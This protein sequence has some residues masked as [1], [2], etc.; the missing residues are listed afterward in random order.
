MQKIDINK[1]LFEQLKKDYKKHKKNKYY[2]SQLQCGFD[3]MEAIIK[4]FGVLSISVVNTMDEELYKDIF[5]KNFK[6]APSLGDFKSLATTSFSKKSKKIISILAINDIYNLLDDL[7]NRKSELKLP[8]INQLLEGKEKIIKI[9]STIQLLNEYAISFRNKLK[10]HGA[11]FRDED[12]EQREIILGALDTLL[13][14]LEDNYNI[15]TKEI[16]FFLNIE[17][18]IIM[19][20]KDR[21]CKLLPII[22]YIECDKFSCS[23]VHKTKLFFYNDGKETKSHY[24]DYSYNH[25]HQITQN[26][27]IHKELKSLQEEILHTTSDIGRQ[28]LLLSTFVGRIEEL[29]STQE[30]ICNA[31]E[32]NVASFISIMGK[33]GIGKS[34]FLTQL[35]QRLEEDILL[36]NKFNSY[37]FYAQKDKMGGAAEEEKYLWKKLSNYFDKYG[38]SIKQDSNELFNLRDNLEKLFKAYEEKQENKPLLLMIDGLDEFAKPSVIVESIPLNISTKIHFI[39]SSRPYQNIKDSLTTI[40]TANEQLSILKAEQT[41]KEGYSLELNKLYIEEV[42]ELLSR[43]LSKDISRE[44]DEYKEIVDTIVIQSESLP[45][46]IYYITQELKEKNIKENQNIAEEII[47]WSKQLPPKLSNFYSQQFKAITPLARSILFLLLLSKSSVSKEDFYTLLKSIKPQE[48]MTV[49]EGIIDEVSFIEKHFNTIEVFLIIDSNKRYT[50]Y[51]HSVKEQ[52]IIYLQEIKQLFTFNKQKLKELLFEN[53]L[54]YYSK[55]VESIL[56]LTKDSDIYKLLLGLT[57]KVEKNTTPS[58]Y[59]DNYFHL[60][61]TFIWTKIYTVQINHED[62]KNENY[63]VLL[64]LQNLNKENKKEIEN[65]HKLFQDKKEKYLYEIRYGYELAFITKKYSQVLLYKDM[66]EKNVQEMFLEIAL[67][68]DKHINIKK[69]IKYKSDWLNALS[70]NVQDVV[71]AIIAKQNSLDDSFFEVL[72]FLSDKY[73]IEL[74]H[75]IS[76]QKADKII[77]TIS[78]EWKKE[79]AL[80]NIA[81][82]TFNIE[83]ALKV[84]EQLSDIWYKENILVSIAAK[85]DNMDEINDILHSVSDKYNQSKITVYLVEKTQDFQQALQLANNIAIPEFKVKA[86]SILAKRYDK[87]LFQKAIQIAN[88]ISVDEFKANSLIFIAKYNQSQEIFTQVLEISNTISNQNSKKKILYL[89]VKNTNNSVIV[90]KVLNTLYTLPKNNLSIEIFITIALKTNDIQLLYKV[91]EFTRTINTN[92]EKETLCTQIIKVINDKQEALKIRSFIS[93]PLRKEYAKSLIYTN[94]NQSH[95]L[96]YRKNIEDVLL[97]INNTDNLQFLDNI[98][99]N[100]TSISDDN[101]DTGIILVAIIE[102]TNNIKIL[103]ES[104]KILDSIYY[105]KYKAIVL[106]SFLKKPKEIQEKFIFTNSLSENFYKAKAF[107]KIINIDTNN[108]KEM[109]NILEITQEI[110]DDEYRFEALTAIIVKTTEKTILQE[111]FSIIKLMSHPKYIQKT[112]LILIEQTK[113]EKLL[114]EILKFIL[115]LNSSIQWKLIEKLKMKLQNINNIFCTKLLLNDLKIVDT[116]EILSIL[117]YKSILEYYNIDIDKNNFLSTLEQ[118]K[119]LKGKR[120]KAEE[121]DDEEYYDQLSQKAEKIKQEILKDEILLNKILEFYHISKI[122]LKKKDILDIT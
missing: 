34:A 43:V 75:T 46:Y 77:N 18:K 56:Y 51:H 4:F 32:N 3:Y 55:S 62:M 2:Q 30:L 24:I 119:I 53:F 76:I 68:I 84:K 16:N 65:F 1:A 9:K 29:N 89:V 109:I 83:E 41:L 116:I 74:I 92:E 71:I 107:A 103:Q 60:L 90:E 39:Y 96:K 99:K 13:L 45:L 70:S 106:A 113:D 47:E 100:I 85:L 59:K 91:L 8:D 73:K 112:L 72:G 10:G 102:K 98:L 23:K 17:N 114:E 33:P 42:E 101:K 27:S 95:Q 104:I 52:L 79:K 110:N 6:L 50:F 38:T 97:S 108:Q 19:I 94:L 111:V 69:F 35:Q 12:S 105:Y 31:I 25:F 63:S 37:I 122:Q 22:S 64:E 93:D 118:L 66:Y 26:N 117:S 121:D 67:N 57:Q 86:L 14:H 54:E 36:K 115:S 40:L 58:Y 80:Y 87:D 28:T 44:S 7:F 15:L 120:L 81:T 20:Y 48:F 88:S 61:Y 49:N 5:T 78:D 82:K 11:T 21:H